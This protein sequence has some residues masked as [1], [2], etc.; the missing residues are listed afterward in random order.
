MSSVGVGLRGTLVAR[1]PGLGVMEGRRRRRVEGREV[2]GR[3]LLVLVVDRL[4][5]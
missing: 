1:S 2:H 3:M 5:G 4:S